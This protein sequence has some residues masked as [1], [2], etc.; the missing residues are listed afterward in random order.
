L[1]AL[2]APKLH[3]IVSLSESK[4]P[5]QQEIQAQHDHRCDEI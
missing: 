3:A 1:A 5:L 2:Q 4:E